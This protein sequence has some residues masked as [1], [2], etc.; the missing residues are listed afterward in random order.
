[1][2]SHPV[3]SQPSIDLSR[4]VPI[5]LHMD[6]GPFTK[7]GKSAMVVNF[8]SVLADGS[9]KET[10]FC[11]ATWIKD[12]H[13]KTDANHEPFWSWLR[14]S[15]NR[16]SCRTWGDKNLDGS[17]FQEGSWRGSNSNKQLEWGAVHIGNKMDLEAY[18]S[19][20]GW[21]GYNS[22]Q[23]C[24]LCRCNRSDRPW[25]DFRDAAA[26]RATIMSAAEYSARYSHCHPLQRSPGSTA[27]T[28]FSDSMHVLDYQGVT[29]RVA[30]WSNG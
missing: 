19:E 13:T 28:N 15:F 30:G 25:T 18:V 8:S 17:M 9:D 7:K 23:P 21:N 24:G 12:K 29:S 3:L 4:L 26:W 10:V 11:I 2:R 27:M 1:M 5:V 16:L 22:N 14:E 20:Q 6:A